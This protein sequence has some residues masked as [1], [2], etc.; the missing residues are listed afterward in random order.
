[1]TNISYNQKATEQVEDPINDQQQQDQLQQQLLQQQQQQNM[2]GTRKRRGGISSETLSEEPSIAIPTVPKTRETQDRL[3]QALE[4]NIMFNH[5]EE[6]ERKGLFSAMVE[7]H[8]KSGDVIIRQ[9]DEGDN[10]YVVDSGVCDIFVS[11]NGATPVLVMEV[12]EG[13]SFGE[14][15]LINFSPRAA[16]VI[17]KTDVRLWA[18]NRITY[19]KILMDQTMTKRKMYE[20]FLEKVSILK[21]ID[22]YERISLADALEPCNFPAGDVIVKQGEPGDK[23][24]IIVEGEVLVSHQ[25]DLNDPSSSH[26]VIRL[27]SGDY[28]GEI[29][30]LLDQP[31]AASVTAI[32]NTKCVEM[33]RQRFIRLLGPCEN[34]LRRNMERYNQYMTSNSPKLT[35]HN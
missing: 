8:Y 14:L 19:R 18:L 26:E 10:F 34:I 2:I 33:D 4:K 3:D 20:E 9:G 13:G 6:E 1:M 11:K 31:R 25:T 29:A 23:F 35:H 27:H 24:Y 12:F 21:D 28:F 22:R 16:T 15:A 5:L 32:T 17:A 30:L 7:V